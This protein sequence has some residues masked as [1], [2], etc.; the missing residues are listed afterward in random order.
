VGEALG[1]PTTPPDAE[2]EEPLSMSWSV[3][4]ILAVVVMVAIAAFWSIVFLGIPKKEN[5][6]RLDDRAFV[7]RTARRCDQ[8]LEDLAGLPNASFVDDHR[9]RADVLDEATD[10]VEEMVDAI[11]ADAPEEGDDGISLRGW[12]ADWRT[13]VANRRDYADRLRDDPDARFLLDQSLGGDSV[14]KPIEIFADV[15]DMPS[16]ATPG[17]VG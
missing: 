7:E 6:D 4:R 13:Y 8:L 2:V 17:D 11:E 15:N 9:E 5:P 12:I 14:D 3:G 1:V 10:L 16:C